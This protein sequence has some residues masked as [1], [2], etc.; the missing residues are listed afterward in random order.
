MMYLKELN[1]FVCNLM[2]S[3]RVTAPQL[4]AISYENDGMCYAFAKNGERDFFI[5]APAEL[6]WMVCAISLDE[7][8]ERYRQWFIDHLSPYECHSE[9]LTFRGRRTLVL[10]HALQEIRA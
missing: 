3:Y 2:Q 8:H 4:Q 7:V 6:D 1:E 9:G 10:D 5:Y